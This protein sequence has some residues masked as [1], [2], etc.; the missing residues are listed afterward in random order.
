MYVDDILLK[1]YSDNN[2]EVKS[3]ISI[4]YRY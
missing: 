3:I 4:L 1:T 2:I